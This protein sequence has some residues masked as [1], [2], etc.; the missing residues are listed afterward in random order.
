MVQIGALT[1]VQLE[2]GLEVQRRTGERLG[3]V[4][5]KLGYITE[6]HL[7]GVLEQQLGMKRV[8][9]A[10]YVVAE[11]V[12]KLVPE[13]MARRYKVL[14]LE[15][16]G[17]KLTLAMADPLNVFAIDDIKLTTGL[18][19]NPVI[20]AEDE[21]TRALDQ[22]YGDSGDLDEVVRD[23]VTATSDTIEVSEEEEDIGI[24]RLRELVDEAPVVRLVNMIISQAVRERAS[25]IH[26]E[27]QAGS[28]RV[29]FRIDGMLREIMRP[30]R[31]SHAAIASR[32]KI[33]SNMDIAERRV[34]QDGRVQ[35][36]VEGQD[37]DLR[38]STL[39]TIYGEKVV[40]RVLFR[41]G[42]MVRLEQ[43]G[44]LPDKLELWYRSLAQPY[45]IILV[46]GPTGSGK[47]QTLYASLNQLNLP[48]K[49]IITI[50]DPVE[51]R[52]EGI[53]Q[54]Q[55]NPKAG[56]TF[57][58]GLRSMLRQDPDIIMVGEIRDR[59]TA[60]IAVNAALTGH[61]VLSTLHT[62]DAP[63][64]PVRLVDMDVEPFLVA[65]SIICI[66]AQR[67]VRKICP[68]CQ[69]EYVPSDETWE[70]WLRI[71]GGMSD[72]PGLGLPRKLMKG[73][74]C[75]Q[76]GT[77]GYSGRTAIHEILMASEKIRLLISSR[78]TSD[79][80]ATAARAAGMQ[81][82]V[83]DGAEKVRLGITTIEEVMRVSAGGEV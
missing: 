30:P 42:A 79:E 69:E 77:T 48:E 65:S 23:L 51:F 61:L 29:R 60:G 63:G 31:R 53:N 83:E 68:H 74:G 49:N 16:A 32:F 27:P 12:I 44:F 72:Q 20:A 5:V 28:V 37:I 43:L 46:T 19:V 24:D 22:Y 80:I 41:R 47:T 6:A 56:L 35:L 17:K 34:P 50:E 78:A 38:V 54:V 58:N 52:L 70:R 9:L 11:D 7:A 59:E 45:G 55:I 1:P 82:L 66:L 3:R 81:R 21:L 67:L 39:P 25:D 33:M 2:E 73:R 14:P 4:L 13:A 76:C 71:T 40:C 18:D 75:R 57:A 8:S 64:A 15:M 26:V 62:N 10:E 36:K